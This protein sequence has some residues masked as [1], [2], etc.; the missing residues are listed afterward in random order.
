M[1]QVW[2][3]LGAPQGLVLVAVLYL[4]SIGVGIAQ[5]VDP[6]Y[7]GDVAEPLTQVSGW[8]LM[9]GAAGAGVCALGGWWAGERVFILFAFLGLTARSF[10]TGF[11]ISDGAAEAV[12]RAGLDMLAGGWLLLRALLIW[13][14]DFDPTRR[15]VRGDRGR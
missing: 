12:A 14:A 5:V 1:T 11:W 6:R 7:Y 3:R 13:G 8:L 4:I 15:P 10:V 2:K 9:L